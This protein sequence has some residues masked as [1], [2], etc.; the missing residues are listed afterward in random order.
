MGKLF[1]E[2]KKRLK[3]IF[4]LPSYA[5]VVCLS[6]RLPISEHIRTKYH[7]SVG[8]FGDEVDREVGIPRGVWDIHGYDNTIPP[9]LE[10]VYDSRIV[11]IRQV[12][13]FLNGQGI[14]VE[15]INENG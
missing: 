14:E 13:E 9:T 3:G 7:N 12:I 10:V 11:E 1:T 5:R 2:I 6:V 15:S 4:S 8:C